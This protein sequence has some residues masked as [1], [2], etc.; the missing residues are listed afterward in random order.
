VVGALLRALVEA[1]VALRLL[2]REALL[3]ILLE[4]ELLILAVSF[5]SNQRCRRNNRWGSL[6]R[7]ERVRAV[8]RRTQI[9]I[10]AIED[11]RLQ[12]ALNIVVVTIQLEDLLHLLR[13][14][15]NS[16]PHLL[17]IGVKAFNQLGIKVLPL[18]D[19]GK[20]T[21]GDFLIK[22]LFLLLK[23]ILFSGLG[24]A[25]FNNIEELLAALKYT[26][27]GLQRIGVLNLRIDFSLLNLEPLL[28]LPEERMNH[29]A[30]LLSNHLGIQ[31]LKLLDCAVVLV[32]S[33][34]EAPIQLLSHEGDKFNAFQLISKYLGI[35][36][37]AVFRLQIADDRLIGLGAQLAS[38]F[39]LKSII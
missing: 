39:H 23:L 13:A 35:R 8:G 7:V 30:E 2:C 17:A 26:F 11:E 36:D 1:V 29:L 10:D 38:V 22:N 9:N 19:R 28:Q 34:H 3:E 31:L 18:D 37:H 32:P 6:L 20:F 33:L 5:L 21:G 16:F 25:L 15:V 14:Q 12:L 4:L 27:Q 24:T